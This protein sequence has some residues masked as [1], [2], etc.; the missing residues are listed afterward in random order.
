MKLSKQAEQLLEAIDLA[1]KE[2]GVLKQEK[3]KPMGVEVFLPAREM[4]ERLKL[5][6][7][8]IDKIETFMFDDDLFRIGD[9]GITSRNAVYLEKSGLLDKKRPGV[10]WR[11]L[12]LVDAVY[13]DLL[14]ELRN[15]G[16]ST[17]KLVYLKKAF[18][19][20]MRIGALF[21]GAFFGFEITLII[22]KDGSG[23]IMDPETYACYQMH[24]HEKMGSPSYIAI[25]LNPI[26]N[27]S[28]LALEMPAIKVKYKAINHI[29]NAN[30]DK[31]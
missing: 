1:E 30:G 15:Y 4:W 12:S 19:D 17:K 9:T 21:F 22:H 11:K 25:K 2:L 28:L 31:K 3:K 24:V 10:G 20:R 16:M 7:S 23:Y 29:A 27:K 18:E 6:S 14:L 8:K 13:F 5:E 26:I